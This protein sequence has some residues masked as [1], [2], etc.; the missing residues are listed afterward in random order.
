M[1]SIFTINYTGTIPFF[2]HDAAINF[3]DAVDFLLESGLIE[4]DK[5][6]IRFFTKVPDKIKKELAKNNNLKKVVIINDWVSH[7][8]SLKYQSESDL[9]LLLGGILEEHKKIDTGKI[10]EYL[11]AKKPILALDFEDSHS[12]KIIK[13]TNTGKVVLVGNKKEIAQTIQRYYDDFYGSGISY[14]P[15]NE[16]IQKYNYQSIAKKLN[17]LLEKLL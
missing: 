12:G 8:E 17:F 1:D 15:N 7:K 16:E 6:R 14:N 3:F 4:K 10:Y 9:L 2:W 11:I 13:K 5:I